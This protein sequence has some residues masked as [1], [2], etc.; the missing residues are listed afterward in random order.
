VLHWRGTATEI[1]DQA[2]AARRAR[3]A[4]EDT[5]AAL[6]LRATTARTAPHL[7]PTEHIKRWLRFG[8]LERRLFFIVLMG[9]LPLVLLSFA[10]LLYNARNQREDLLEATEDT[11]RA[12]MT[13]VDAEIESSFAALDVLAVSPLLTAGNLPGF[14]EEARA[15]LER[16]TGWANIV[17]STPSGQQLLNAKL[18]YS[19]NPP[20]HFD[21]RETRATARSGVRS[22]GDIVLSPV[23][24]THVFAVRVPV[25][26]R[27]SVAYVLTAM[28]RPDAIRAALARQRIPEQGVVGVFDHSYNVVARTLNHEAWIGKPAASGLREILH[29]GTQGGWG[30][31]VTLEGVPVYSVYRRSAVTNWVAAV[32]IPMSVLDAPV[33]R[34]YGVLGGSILVSLLLGF[35]A[36]LITSRTITQPMRDL[37]EAAAAV[38]EG[39]LPK[40][41][42][43]SLPEVRRAAVALAVAHIEREKLLQSE[44]EARLHEEQAR[45]LAEAASR[46]KDEFLAMLGHELRNPLAAIM[47][48]SQIIERVDRSP[49]DTP[50]AKAKAIIRRQASHLG[51]LTDDLLDAGRVMT[52]K[53]NL[54]P[55]PADLAVLVQSSIDTL[56]NTGLFAQ[57]ELR[58]DLHSVWVDVDATRVDQVVA[59]L[60]TNAV[61]YT[62]P[63][64]IVTV[65][66]GP[67]DEG[68]QA[69][70]RVRDSGIGLEPSLLPRIFDLFVQGQRALDRS[71]GGLGIGLTL[72]RRLVELHGGRI[73]AVSAGPQQ[74]SEFSIRL[75][76][77]APVQHAESP[78][79]RGT[80]AGCNIVIVEDNEDVRTSL[81]S[82]LESEGHVVRVAT[83]G[84]SGVAV[85]SED[86]AQIALIDVGLP[87]MDGYDVA[88]TVR[89]RKERAIRLV[90]M[91]GYGANDDI[92]RGK[93]AGF[94]AY[95]IKPVDAAR[96][97]AVIA[98][99]ER[100]DA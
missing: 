100:S 64:G 15:L 91:T 56:R 93:R 85:L 80:T 41:P 32:G 79:T 65:T 97:S 38:G 99:S 82:L 47:N 67:S 29:A 58:L 14:Y 89:A 92:E 86:W 39:H 87:R 59:N 45:H 72:V 3:Q 50:I 16:H 77:I 44:R 61:K 28:V 63:P 5:P 31:T 11:M 96:L 22:V 78:P 70:L 2:A 46:A 35:A 7:S 71:Q 51:R 83:D 18:A 69:C 27:G 23:V 75:P 76:A 12:M 54:S 9:V 25:L 24:K 53:I 48:A 26:E 81:Q 68:D 10:A 1:E 19:T 74:G 84:P 98:E 42:A 17:L 37:E 57:H 43:T 20:S 21:A 55:R 95:L 88:R 66:V 30:T 52:G 8:P 90:A 94:D 13:A 49:P 60:L 62:P 33:Y 73:E 36:A 6:A 34:S 4:R 40:V